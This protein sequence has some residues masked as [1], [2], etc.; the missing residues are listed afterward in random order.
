[1]AAHAARA[2]F[3][4]WRAA[5]VRRDGVGSGRRRAEILYRLQKSSAWRRGYERCGNIEGEIK[6]G[7][8]SLKLPPSGGRSDGGSCVSKKTIFLCTRRR[9][10]ERCEKVLG[11]ITRT[12]A[13]LR[14][15]RATK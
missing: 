12:K 14:L 1:M 11:Y 10:K 6:R 9:K 8:S 3:C 15:R 13:W 2:C 5:G 4:R 7:A